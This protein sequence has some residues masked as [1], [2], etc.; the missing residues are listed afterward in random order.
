MDFCNFVL[1]I[2]PSHNPFHRAQVQQGGVCELPWQV[3]V[4]VGELQDQCCI[5]ENDRNGHRLQT[6]ERNVVD[7]ALRHANNNFPEWGA[8]LT[9]C[10]LAIIVMVCKRWWYWCAINVIDRGVKVHEM[11]D[12]WP[13][14]VVCYDVGDQ[15][16]HQL[17]PQ[18]CNGLYD[19]G[20]QQTAMHVWNMCI[21]HR[22]RG[23]LL[24]TP[25]T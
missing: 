24:L 17:I 13:K 10:L 2:Q 6:T 14:Q 20:A 11:L 16:L 22:Q 23:G 4:W 21:W 7:R 5:V 3:I 8:Q 9:P 19:M 12:R 25:L 15:R 18:L 1:F